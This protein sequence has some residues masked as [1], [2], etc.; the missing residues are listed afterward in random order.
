MLF[1]D[2]RGFTDSLSGS[3]LRR[4]P[5]QRPLWTPGRDYR[6]AWGL[7]RRLPQDAVP[8]SSALRPD[9]DRGHAVTCAIEIRAR[10]AQNE[11]N[12]LR[13]WPPRR[14]EWGL[15][16]ARWWPAIWARPIGSSTG[17]L[18]TLSRGGGS[19]RLLCGQVL[20]SDSTRQILIDCGRRPLEVEEG[21]GTWPYGSGCLAPRVTRHSCCP[22]ARPHRAPP[23]DRRASLPWCRPADPPLGRIGSAP[24]WGDRVG[25]TWRSVRCSPGASADQRQGNASEYTDGK[26]IALANTRCTDGSRRFTGIDCIPIRSGVR[27]RDWDAQWHSPN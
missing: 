14:W 17:S 22:G 10:A 18:G 26:V 24:G 9:A 21:V 8:P 15:I 11:H 27:R 13:G 6:A 1:S 3:V 4:W 20:I 12:C 19:R 16:P 7:R 2:L 5:S 23:A 25:G